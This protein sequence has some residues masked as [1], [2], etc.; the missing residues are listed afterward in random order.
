M[1][2][3]SSCTVSMRKSGEAAEMGFVKLLA[4]FVITSLSRRPILRNRR[5]TTAGRDIVLCDVF[6][7]CP[8]GRGTRGCAMTV[9][10]H[11]GVF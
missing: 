8:A 3:R 9:V 11:T 6:Q 5:K 10:F 1:M 7:T 4:E 2:G